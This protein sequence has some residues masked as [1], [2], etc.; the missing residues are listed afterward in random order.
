ME[1]NV[2]AE[3]RAGEE[4]GQAEKRVLEKGAA[5]RL[6]GMARGG[7]MGRNG[8]SEGRSVEGKD[9]RRTGVR[10]GRCGRGRAGGG[11]ENVRKGT[12]EGEVLNFVCVVLS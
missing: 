4:A 7:W 3:T 5:R 12:A 1:A 2:A 10:G 11:V 6:R 8:R 9:G